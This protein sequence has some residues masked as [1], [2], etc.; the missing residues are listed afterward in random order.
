[1]QALRDYMDRAGIS[2]SELARRLNTDRWQVSRW[3]RG[4][5]EPSLATRKHISSTLRIVLE[6]LL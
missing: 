3:M 4:H 1:M 5:V 6:K 2:Q